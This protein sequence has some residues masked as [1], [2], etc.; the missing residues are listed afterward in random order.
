MG[1]F[2]KSA[3][4]MHHKGKFTRL[5]FLRIK[6]LGGH[7]NHHRD[8]LCFTILDKYFLR[9]HIGIVAE[10]HFYCNRVYAAT[11]LQ[12]FFDRYCVYASKFLLR[13]AR[14][15]AISLRKRI[16]QQSLVWKLVKAIKKPPRYLSE[17][18]NIWRCTL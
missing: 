12:K 9:G 4:A 17:W 10:C 18:S 16:R 2:F 3:Q 11:V 15:F 8:L 7:F 14:I 1:L 5:K 6:N 13:L